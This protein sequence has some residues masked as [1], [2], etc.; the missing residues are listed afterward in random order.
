[1]IQMK[2]ISQKINVR[3]QKLAGQESDPTTGER[4]KKGI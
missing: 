2:L 3:K 4:Q 1:M